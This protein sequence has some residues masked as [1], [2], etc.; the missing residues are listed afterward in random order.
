[1][2]TFNYANAKINLTLDVLGRRGDGYHEVAMIL[3]EIPLAD[4]VAVER[5]ASGIEVVVPSFL[6]SDGRNT[7]YKAARAF[8][9]ETGITGGVRIEIRKII[10]VEAGLAGGS[11][12]A[13]AVLM[14]MNELFEAGLSVEKLKE[15]GLRIGADVPFCIMGGAAFACGIGERLTAVPTLPTCHIVICKPS[16]GLSTAE[17]Y[18]RIDSAARSLRP[19]N[20]AMIAALKAHD[21]KAVALNLCNVMEEVSVELIPEIADIK[22]SMCLYGALNACM[23]GSGPSV[24]GIFD[25]EMSAKAAETAF[26]ED[27]TQVFR[28]AVK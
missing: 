2:S 4:E 14:G 8:F 17:I 15:I 21:L 5:T 9:A 26:K 18:R 13:A 20:N 12:D 28:L 27:Y 7:A 11:A 6:P 23:S 25:D 3:H 10:P 19:D 22:R 1:M 16:K 24:F